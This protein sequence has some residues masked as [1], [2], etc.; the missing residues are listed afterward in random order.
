[1]VARFGILRFDHAQFEGDAWFDEG[2]TF[3]GAAQFT[4]ATFKGAAQ[5]TGATFKGAAQFTGATFK[6]TAWFDEGTTFEGAA[7]FD[8]ATFK[9]D[10]WFDGATFKDTAWFDEGTT[11]EGAAQF[12][13]A[14]FKGAAQF[15]GATFKD[16]A[17]FDEGTTFEGAARFDKATFKGDTWFDGATFKGDARFDKATFK[18][19]T[20]FTGATFK[21]T[22]WFDETTFKGDARFGKTTFEAAAWFDETTFEAAAWF[23]ET[24]FEAA[25][26]FKGAKF[27]DEARFD[28]ARFDSAATLGPLIAVKVRLSSAVF[29]QLVVVE[30]EAGWVSCDRARFQAGVTLRVRH[31]NVS[32]QQVSFGGPS[33]LEGRSQHFRTSDN[34]TVVSASED[35]VHGW[36]T[37]AAQHRAQIE[38]ERIG[39]RTDEWVPGLV[40]LQGTDVSELVLTDV[41]L[42]WCRFAGAHHLDKLRIE[43]R[44]PFHRPPSGWRAGWTWLPVWRWTSRQ[45][46]AEEH[47]WRR[48][49]RTSKAAGWQQLGSGDAAV[50]VGAERLAV[51]YRSLRKA[52]EDGKDEAGAGDFYYGEMEARR[53]AGP[54]R[55][56]VVLS[57]YWLVSGYG[58]R[59]LRA[60]VGLAVLVI[61]LT[62]LLV[63]WGLPGDSPGQLVT[64]TLPA[65]SPTTQQT[66][67]LQIRDAPATL[68]PPG[69]C[70]TWTR[71]GKALQLALGS[72]A[73]RD[74]GQKL[75]PAGTW[76]VMTGR[77]LG[78]L[79]LALAVLAVRA[80]VKR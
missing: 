50:E 39:T 69:Q 35:Q 57:A 47:A 80:R 3:E 17:W 59:A 43:G 48:Q 1:M 70:W 21:D 67:A 4:G 49:G 31:A 61:V 5:F 54:L 22:A 12:T 19:D 11:F 24:T 74:A 8:K 16:T 75:T 14:T 51:L 60:V 52:L 36:P 26:G 20:Q 2:T 77:F 10:T 29:S 6:D 37:R 30:L 68:P 38:G 79:F 42:R 62:V 40:A 32:L 9:G 46:L 45:V 65:S 53:H 72:V 56:R 28:F 44:S 33:S 18:G 13:G 55:D 71:A 64:G 15:T 7:R 23:D 66:V 34:Q 76:T 78:P 27:S 25:A 41:D 73:F 58:Q 63:G